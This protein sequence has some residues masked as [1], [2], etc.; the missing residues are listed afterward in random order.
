M[1]IPRTIEKLSSII[2]ADEAIKR[3]I[4][5][6]HINK[7]QRGMA[8]LKLSYKRHIEYIVGQGTSKTS[9]PGYYALQNK[10]L[11]KL[12]LGLA[13]INV[14]KGEIFSKENINEISNYAKKINYPVVAKPYNGSH[15]S[16]VYINI[17]NENEFIKA[18]KKILKTTEYVLVEKMFFGTEYRMI[19][20]RDKF[21]T[22]ANRIPANVIGDGVHT[23]KEL[24]EIKNN[25][26]RRGFGHEKSLLKIQIDKNVLET[27]KEKN[28]KLDYVAKKGRIIYLRKNSNISTGGDSID[29]TDKI[30]PELKKIAVRAIRAIP[31]LEYGGIDVLTNMDI[32]KKPTK[33][34]YIVI[35]VNLSPMIS[36]HHFPYEGKP[37]NVAKEVIDILFP[38]T[39]RKYIGKT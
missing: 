11:T 5:I 6:S 27:L 33:K 31:G 10:A 28:I 19:A 2:L 36:M 24:V 14:S 20:S 13:K 12:F 9:Y 30:H 26:P 1:K 18:A 35:E 29:V 23:I 25:D 38:E 8:F 34:S 39:K 22:A 3:G 32:S 7:R 4:K 16:L 21:I 15:G 17:Q 37:R